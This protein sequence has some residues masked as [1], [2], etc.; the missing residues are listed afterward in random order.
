MTASQVAAAD[1]SRRTNT[2]YWHG[3]PVFGVICFDCHAA[4]TAGSISQAKKRHLDALDPVGRIGR[5]GHRSFQAI[6]IEIAS[7]HGRRIQEVLCERF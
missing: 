7:R 5:K 4:E 1:W 6:E 2:H 3:C